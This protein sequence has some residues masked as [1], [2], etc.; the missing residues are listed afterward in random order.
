MNLVI[1]P[2]TDADVPAL[3]R[4]LL[5]QQP[6]SGYPLRAPLPMPA[7]EFVA[8]PGTLAAWSALLDDEPVGHI[9]V[10]PVEPAETNRDPSLVRL[11]S[12][13]HDLPAERLGLIGVYFTADH[14]RGRGVGAALMRTALNDLAERGLAPCL[15]AINAGPTV[16][17]YRRTG[18]REVGTT[19]TWWL[20]DDHPDVVAMIRPIDD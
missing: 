8:R 15:D 9:A 6:G 18:W 16:D 19:R 7:E 14:V 13:G 2:R 4:A 12:Q 20:P 11:W 5:E 3:A 10:H 1:R 17:P